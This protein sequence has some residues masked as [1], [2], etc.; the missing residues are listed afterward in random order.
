MNSRLKILT[1]I[2]CGLSTMFS[3]GQTYNMSNTTI[4]TCSGTFYDTGGSA[5]AYG[6]N[7]F[8]TMTFC[9][10]Q[11][12]DEI[13]FDFTQFQVESGW[14]Y[15]YV[16]DGPTTGSPQ[17][18]GSPFSGG[19]APG[20]I[21][22]S[23]GCLTF[24]FTSDGSVTQ[25]G[26]TATIS[27]ATPSCS[28][29]IQNQGETGI[30]CGGPC[31][32]PC[33][34]Y[35]ISSGGTINSCSGTFYDSGGLAGTYG[36]NEF[37]TI[38]FCS[39][40]PG[41]EI[42]FDFTQFQVE[43]GWDYLYVY[44]GPTTGS[45]QLTGSP[46]SGGNTP[47]TISSSNGCLTFQFTSDGSVTQDG[48]TATISCA[49][50]SCTDGIQNQGETG[51][52]CG[53]PCPTAC[54][55][56]P[57][58]GG[59]D[60]STLSPICTQQA[61]TFTANSNGTPASTV[62]PGNNYDCLFS[63]PNPAWYFLEIST[64]GAID[65]SLS[66]PS[67]IDFIIY[68]P[69]GDT[70][71]AQNGCGNYGNGG[72][73]SGVVDCSYS[74]T[75]NETPSIPNAQVGE[76]YV[77]LITN[78]SNQVQQIT[79]TQT[80]GAGGTDCSV[81]QPCNIDTGT[82]ST[83]MVCFEG[84]DEDLFNWLGG[85]PEIGG[86][87]FDPMGNPVT[88]PI[89]PST[90]LAG[91]YEY[92]KDSAGCTS[93]SYIDLQIFQVTGT[94]SVTN[95]D[96]Q[97]CNGEIQVTG[98][99]GTAPYS[100]SDD[101]GVTFQASNTFTGLCGAAT[102]GVNYSFLIEDALGCQGTVDDF[103]EDINYPTLNPIVVADASCFSVCDGSATLSG[104]NLV[105]YSID[106]GTTT[107]AN[108]NFTGL[109][110][111]TYDVL[112]D[113]G[114]GCSVTDAFTVVEPPVLDIS[115]ISPDFTVCA[116]ETVTA[117]VN[118]VNGIGNVVY[119]WETGGNVLGTGST[120]DIVSTGT[121]VVC[122]TMSDDCPT[123]DTECLNITEPAPVIPSFSTL[124]NSGCEP[125]TVTF[126]NTSNGSLQQTTWSFSDGTVIVANGLDSVTHQFVNPGTYDVT[127]NIVTSAGCIED[128]TIYEYITVYENPTAN[129]THHPNPSTIF[130]TEI[131][132]TDY[133]SSDVVSWYWEFGPGVLP[134]ISNNQ[135]PT[136]VFPEGIANDYPVTLTVNTNEGCTNSIT[137]V[138]SIVNDV[139]LY[140]PNIFT[141]DGDA[142]NDS[143]RVYIAGIDIYDYHL[144]I[145]N[146]WGEII[147]ESYNAEGV[148]NGH[149][150]DGGL[151]QD[152]TYIWVI[153]AKDS[154]TDK[155][156]EFR[157]HVTVLK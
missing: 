39:D 42:I 136:V 88:M 19:N 60:C 66:A 45:P 82:D 8:I 56:P 99:N 48:W 65:M 25:A 74:A 149:Y 124:E 145:F 53:G 20:T 35:L 84:P 37:S 147:W 72:T 79:L 155:K 14:D 17:L 85:T 116:G 130:D 13:I 83:A 21:S 9:S 92:R 87:W 90:A 107:Q 144:T 47:G 38:T 143:W 1:L 113:N 34:D 30:D 64:A 103:V 150:G 7:E 58:P 141:P 52:D 68:G 114:F 105:N 104:T 157:G 106:N 154:Y 32:N 78:Y 3:Y 22:S 98:A 80:G 135:N 6:N 23:N 152:G 4:N 102:P 115:S 111:G 132:F 133:S 97:A 156:Y 75:N 134:G 137:V 101:G 15:L 96:C 112:V 125:F 16:Y 94:T 129:F 100:Y 127:M 24:Q 70:T 81:L 131:E 142:A 86:N 26:W 29:G 54:P 140:A 2:A 123:T 128:T 63:S 31:P 46:F 50:P 43:N 44:D 49:T 18:A 91:S 110:P 77:M 41:D 119:T 148:W 151:V 57:A 27:C 117:A 11:P 67:D 93:S 62:D 10:D 5:G 69:F 126:Q 55:Q 36:N 33:T 28:D 122:A 95:S 12:G 59:T 40:Q 120:I 51:I 153:E 109:C 108:G 139:L 121:M 76:V 61:L 118:G 71:A 73:G 146:R 138:V 89:S